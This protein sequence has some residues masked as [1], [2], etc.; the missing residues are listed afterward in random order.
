MDEPLPPLAPGVAPYT[1]TDARELLRDRGYVEA[2]VRISSILK[3]LEGAAPFARMQ[4]RAFS[5]DHIRAV[6]DGDF[7]KFLKVACALVPSEKSI[8]PYVFPIRNNKRRPKSVPL[9]AG[10]YCID[11]FTPLNANAWL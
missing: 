6:H 9:R 4:P 2:P 1:G 8:Y 11:T 10:Y 7:V 5:E 3:E